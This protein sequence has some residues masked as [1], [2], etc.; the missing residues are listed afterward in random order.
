MFFV[1]SKVVW[2]VLSPVNFAILLAGLSALLAFTR[3]ARPARWIGLISLAALGLMAFSPLPRAVLRPL[4]DRFPQQVSP[5][6]RGESREGHACFLP[7]FP[8]GLFQRFAACLGASL[9]GLVVH[10]ALDAALGFLLDLFEHVSVIHASTSPLWQW[11]SRLH[12]E[13]RP[14]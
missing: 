13:P 4:E 8:D 2:F 3:F 9:L 7:G 14:G 5:S 11:L 10:E 1:L 12:R 6:W